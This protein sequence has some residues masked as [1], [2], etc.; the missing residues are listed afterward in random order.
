M[1]N[2]FDGNFPYRSRTSASGCCLLGMVFAAG[3]LLWYALKS[4]AYA[5]WWMFKYMSIALYWLFASPF[6]L[7]EYLWRRGGTARTAAIGL[8][9]AFALF[10]VFM[11]LTAKPAVKTA[12]VASPTATQPMATATIVPTSAA[13]SVPTAVAVPTATAVPAPTQPAASAT[14]VAVVASATAEAPAA[15]ALPAATDV[16]A[17]PTAVPAAPADTLDAASL[18]PDQVTD[19]TRARGHITRTVDGDTVRLVIFGQDQAVRLIG[20]DTPETKDRRKPVQCYGK[21]ASEY[22]KK[23]LTGADVTITFEVSQGILDK[24]D[25]PLVYIWLADGTLFNKQL[26]ADGY[27]FEFTYDLPYRYQAEFRAAQADARTNNRGLWAPET[28]AGVA[29]PVTPTP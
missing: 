11:I 2:R 28:C 8:T 22:T 26:I 13:T 16:P 14:P 9:V 29:S 6:L 21:E 25:R 18:T 1:G 24:Y 15:T 19:D 27:A 17:A 20:V 3:A 10:F 5:L 12:V 4:L 7:I 23:T